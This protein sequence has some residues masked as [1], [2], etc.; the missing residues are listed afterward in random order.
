MRTI[1]YAA[2]IMQNRTFALLIPAVVL[3]LGGCDRTPSPDPRPTAAPAPSATTTAAC[4]DGVVVR[5]GIV[6]TAMG[7]RAFGL[8]LVNCGNRPYTV[9][10]YPA[11]RVLDE[12][13]KPLDVVVGH[14]SEPVTAPDAWDAPPKPVTLGPGEK[15][16]ARLVWRNTVTD[17]T[18][19]PVIGA[20]VEVT[21]AEGQRPQIVS[22]DGGVDLGTTGRVGV[23]AWL[24]PPTR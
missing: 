2:A 14:G 19:A 10:G 11:I 13:H 8:D 1:G 16:A 24:T 5:A 7:L 15:A 18:A 22:P 21:P 23:S 9:N 12:E 20:F 6:D 4:P 17:G 3:L